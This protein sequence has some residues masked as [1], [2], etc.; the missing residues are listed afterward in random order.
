MDFALNDDQ[1]LIRETAAS[2]LADASGSAAVRAAMAT[3]SGHDDKV[4]RHLATELGWCATAVPEED[5]GLGLGWVELALLMEEAGRRLLCAPFFATTA[6]ATPTLRTCTPGSEFLGPIAAGEL[7]ATVALAAKGTTWRPAAVGVH[8]VAAGQDFLL[9]GSYGHVIDG[10]SAGLVLAPACLADGSLAL[11][12]INGDAAGLT[13]TALDTFDQTRRL[14][15]LRLDGVRV[16]AEALLA[17][18][19]AFATGMLRA[20]AIAGMLL[21]AEQLGGAQACLAMTLD[22]VGQRQQFGRTIASFQAVKHRCAEMSIR[23]ESTRAAVQGAVRVAAGEAATE[24]LLLEAACAK[25]LASEC[26]FFCAQEAI[27]LHGGVGFTWEFDPQLHFKRAQA[28]SHWL[29]SPDE[30]RS[31]VA[32]HLLGSP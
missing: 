26:Y 18:G 2:F 11:F 12:A 5:G 1:Q 29:G 32:D 15:A 23:I 21:A 27:Q 24:T 3:A 8:G 20:Q 19:P 31:A 16:G 22:Y 25:T 4:W 6:L 30:L 9:T 17:R 28:A 13:R 7:T 10:A 14:A